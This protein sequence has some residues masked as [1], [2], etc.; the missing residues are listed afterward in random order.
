MKTN[1][2]N[3]NTLMKLNKVFAIAFVVPLLL[4]LSLG[5][6][7]QTSYTVSDL[8]LLTDNNGEVVGGA[9]VN[10]RGDVVGQEILAAGARR[11]FLWRG[12]QSLD[13]GT[14]G[15]PSAGARG[16]NALDFVA[17]AADRADDTEHAVLWRI[18]REL[19]PESL[20]SQDLGTFGGDASEGN[21]INDFGF[22]VGF[23]YTPNPDPTFTLQFGQTAHAFVWVGRLHDLGTLGG[24]N[25]IAIG[26]NNK[27]T[28]VGWSQA[29]LD[30]GD[31]G[32]PNLHAAIW[33]GGKITD[34]GSFGGPISLALA[35]NNQDIAVGQSMLPSFSSHAFVWQGGVLTDLGTLPGDSASGASGINDLGLIVGF[36][37]GDAGQ[38]A[39]LWQGGQPIDL[40]ARISDP[41]WQ[42]AVAN[43]INDAGQIVGYG[44]L[45]GALHGFLL[46]PTEQDVRGDTSAAQRA[47]LPKSIREWLKV[48]RSGLDRTPLNRSYAP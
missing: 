17:G 43:S 34:M 11:A 41:A 42:L 45:N 21:G 20:H 10:V 46:T 35:V 32:I 2:T 44:L 23:A 6:E 8:G 7:A 25:S 48:Q 36:S 28:V 19:S 3:G 4:V 22:V 30:L 1:R 9:S 40:N 12:G 37:A 15:G 18:S 27:G 24:P 5:A 26:I 47:Q 38:S 29:S 13:L 39:C 33:K 31:F 16:I 14:L